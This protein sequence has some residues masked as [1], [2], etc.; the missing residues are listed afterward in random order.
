MVKM[1]QPMAPRATS[2]RAGFLWAQRLALSHLTQKSTFTTSQYV[3]S[4]KFL[5]IYHLTKR[6]TGLIWT[7]SDD[8]NDRP[9]GAICPTERRS[10]CRPIRVK[11]SGARPVCRDKVLTHQRSI[12]TSLLKRIPSIFSQIK[13]PVPALLPTLNAA[14]S[15]L[16]ETG[17][18]IVA[19]VASLPTAG[20][21]Q[22]TVREDPKIHGTEAER[23]LFTTDNPAWKKTASQLSEA[24]VGV[25][26]FIA[27]P[28]GAYADVATIG[29]SKPCTSNHISH[30]LTRPQ[31]MFQRSLEVKLSSIPT[32]MHHVI[33]RR[34][35][36]KLPTVSPEKPAIRP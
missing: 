23:K 28:G 32:F 1:A 31:V 5:K 16:Q 12:I 27:A 8:G 17:G 10:F 4:S 2:L 29:K 21:G 15:A 6:E 13:N 35:A 9:G 7:G 14:L 30:D 24:G 11:V 20:P 3:S 34:H 22:L 18:K 33:S 36:R 19:S 25:D 26:F